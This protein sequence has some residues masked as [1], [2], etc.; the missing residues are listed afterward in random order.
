MPSES[1]H[2]AVTSPPYWGL[3]DYGV[4]GQIGLEATP[5]EYIS[6]V[7]EVFRELRRVLRNDGTLWLNM[8]DSYYAAPQG[9]ALG[10]SGLQGSIAPHAQTRLAHAT[11]KAYA[12]CSDMK[13]KDLVGMP[14][15]LAFALRS[16]GW[17][18]RQDIIWA[19]PNPMPESVRDRCTKAHEYIFL[20][21]K[22]DTYYFDAEAIK[23]PSSL[24]THSRGKGVNPKARKD[25]QHSRMRVDR[26]P[27]HVEYERNRTNGVGWGTRGTPEAG[28]RKPSRTKQN[29]SFSAAVNGIVTH[30]NKRSVWVIPTSPFP[31]AHFATFPPRLVM[32]CILAGT[33]EKGCCPYCGVPFVRQIV[34]S[35]DYSKIPAGWDTSVGQSDHHG[36]S[37]NFTELNGKYRSKEKQ[38][39]VRRIGENRN[40]Q[41]DKTGRHDDCFPA[42]QTVG[43]N[44]GCNCSVLFTQ[45]AIPCTVLD[46]FAG[47]GTTG[48]VAASPGRN[49]VGI[50]INP[51]YRDIAM[52]RIQKD[53]EKAHA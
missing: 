44:P 30:R 43:W 48:L 35:A 31:E 11:R 21:S 3:R 49:F 24:F 7:T 20:L 14:W 12:R 34:T 16:D 27:R 26:D 17:Y 23:E 8:G 5:D 39:S 29:E 18:L 45:D 52:K 51:E 1:V 10:S 46:P 13:Q 25:G 40:L 6:T 37:G 32:P 53:Q 2:C 15:L 4:I 33:S 22:S 50:E 19:K 41:R 9:P 47:A 36:K 38:D 28:N 42:T